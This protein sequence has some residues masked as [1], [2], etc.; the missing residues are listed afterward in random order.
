MLAD[1][2]AALVIATSFALL[3]TVAVGIAIHA[4]I[5][6]VGLLAALALIIRLRRTSATWTLAGRTKRQRQTLSHRTEP[7]E[8]WRPRR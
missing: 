3:V 5:L 1:V 6:P 2:F 4:S 8:S 7:E